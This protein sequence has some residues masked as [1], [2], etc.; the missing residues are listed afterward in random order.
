M[1]DINP[2]EPPKADLNAG[3][4]AVASAPIWNPTAAALW[5][6]LFSP[7]FGSVLIGLNWRAL[8]QP[9]RALGAWGWLAATV[10]LAVVLSALPFR[11]GP[12]N[13]VILIAWFRAVAQPQ[14]GW[15]KAHHGKAYAR[16]AWWGPLGIAFGVLILLFLLFF[17][18]IGAEL[19]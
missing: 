19:D 7:I 6:L 11:T 18:T 16:R 15:V 13:I 4:V 8:G 14:I 17:F 5:S 10:V 1:A 12:I 2:F 3:S 9:Q